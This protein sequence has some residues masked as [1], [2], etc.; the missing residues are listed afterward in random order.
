VFITVLKHGSPAGVTFIDKRSPGPVV[1][2]VRNGAN[3][4]VKIGFT[5]GHPW[6]RMNELQ[7]GNPVQLEL[8]ALAVGDRA[9]EHMLHLRF[10]VSRIRGEWFEAAPVLAF[11]K[12]LSPIDG[13][14]RFAPP[15]CKRA[16]AVRGLRSKAAEPAFAGLRNAIRAGGEV[17]DISANGTTSGSPSVTTPSDAAQSVIPHT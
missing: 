3:G 6:K 11:L 9:Q 10:A 7:P 12:T 5:E 13:D 17:F 14:L 16:D 15:D 8:I 4:P 1:Y 2:F